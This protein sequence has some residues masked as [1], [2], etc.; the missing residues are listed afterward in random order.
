MRDI[1]NYN[2]TLAEIAVDFL[3]SL[4]PQDREGTQIE[5][6]KFIRWLGL[7]RKVSEISP[8][9]ISS[10][11]EQ[12]TPSATRLVKSFLNY[13][14]KK[15]VT[16][17]NLAPH[18]RVKK[19]SSKTVAS[20]QQDS[21]A[22]TSLTAEGYVKLETELAILKSQRSRIAEELH[23]AAADKDFRENAPLEAV[24][25]HKSHVETRIRELESTLKSARII[26]ENQ[27]SSKI[28]IGDTVALRDLSSGNEHHYV[29]VDPREAN[30]ALGKI[31]VASPL[32]KVL[33]GKEKGQTV[34]FSAPAGT[35]NYRIEG[36]R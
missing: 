24:R 23:K 6:Y 26:S 7:H 14:H 28:K 34:K 16:E 20:L 5:A 2:P 18:L 8:L 35:F 11:A 12:I 1:S 21:R 10:Y 32:G 29:L 22:S 31:S 4:P 17:V 13:L 19:A 9:D 36:I 27:G 33:S 3:A 25:E 15:G 30:P